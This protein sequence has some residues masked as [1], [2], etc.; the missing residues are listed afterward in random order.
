MG[1]GGDALSV[2]ARTHFRCFE[3]TDFSHMSTPALVVAGGDD[4]SEHLTVAGAAWHADPYHLAPGPKSLLWL[5]GA[6]H[7]L[8]G[9][10]GWDAAETTDES[11]ER[12]RL[13]CAMTTAYLRTQ[14]DLDDNAW[15]HACTELEGSQ[16]DAGKVESK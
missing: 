13:V 4:V 14:L 1:R 10:S 15:A 9:V 6:R 5:S 8:G 16:A 11:P 2:Q 3:A 7:G 12:V